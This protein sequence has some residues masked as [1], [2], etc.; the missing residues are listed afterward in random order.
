MLKVSPQIFDR[1]S[2]VRI[3]S[4][5]VRNLDN[6]STTF[7][8]SQEIAEASQELRETMSG[9]PVIEHPNIACWRAAYREFG[10]KPK[11]YPSSI[12]A[13]TRRI[14]KGDQLPSINPLV[15]IYNLISLQHLLPVGGEDIDQLVGDLQLRFARDQEPMAQMLGRPTPEAPLLGE[16]IY[17]DNQEAV[18]RRWNWR[19]AARTCLSPETR[20]AVLVIEA[21]PPITDQQLSAAMDALQSRV[22][23]QCVGECQLEIHRASSV[24]ST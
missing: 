14:L 6:S 16:V 11:K 24:L 15:D 7:D 13:L 5:V 12:E 2:G 22:V 19:E 8:L 18:C 23:D 17:A 21:L 1:F 9:F 20:N 3:G 10:A 4:L